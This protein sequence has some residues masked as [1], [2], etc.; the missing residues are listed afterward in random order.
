MKE[1]ILWLPDIMPRH[2]TEYGSKAANLGLIARKSITPQ[3]FCIGTPAYFKTMDYAGVLEQV[4]AL[5]ESVQ[6]KDIEALTA[7]SEEI[8]QIINEINIPKEVEDCIKEHYLKLTG[9]RDGVRVAVRSSATAEDLPNASFAGQLETYLNNESFEEV[10]ESII[11]CWASLWA[12]RAIHYRFQKG[13]GQKNT[14]MA[15][16]VQEMVDSKISGVMFTA[17][18]LTNSRKEIYIEAI[19]GLGEAL[20]QGEKS[21]DRYIVAK[22][23]MFIVSKQ[24]VDGEA[25]LVDFNIKWLANEGLKLQYLCYDQP[26]DIEWAFDKGQIYLLQSRPITTLGDEDPEPLNTDKMTPTQQDIWTNINERFP[27]P[28]LP[29]DS[30]IAKMFYLS[31]FS[32]YDQLGYSVPV[33]DWSRVEEGDFPEFFVPPAI[34]LGFG[35]IF[36]VFKFLDEDIAES[37]QYNEN[38]FNKYLNFL[39]DDTIKE[40]PMEIIVEYIEDALKDFQ[41]ANTFRYFLY[42]QYGTWYKVLAALLTLLY[43]EEGKNIQQDLIA[44]HPQATI[45]LNNQLVNLALTAKVN[46]SVQNTILELQPEKIKNALNSFTAGQEFLKEFDDF[47]FKYGDREV[48]QGLGGIAAATWRDNPE[49]VWGMLK[50]ILLT[51]E[52]NLHSQEDILRRRKVAEEKLME[53]TSK[54]IAKVIPVKGLINKLLDYARKYTAFREDSHFYLTQSMPLFRA[55]FLEI[56]KQMVRRGVL[57]DKNDVL[58][59]TYW[60]LKE[61][62]HDIYSLKKVSKLAISQDLK[63][64]KQRLERR[65]KKWMAR[66]LAIDVSDEDVL[67]GVGASSG[68]ISGVCKVIIDPKDLYRLQPGDIL[69]AQSTNPSWTPVFSF[70]GGLVVEYGSA[71][72]HAAIVAREYGI[73]AVMGVKGITKLLKDNDIVTIDGQLGYVQ[74]TGK[75][76]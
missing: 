36:K 9:D 30:V 48:S 54:G 59:F 33:V 45:E 49:V 52:K 63:D 14:G 24:T 74:I 69:V 38:A 20:V 66:N 43:G 22:E 6:H 10:K 35:R 17:N 61:L 68:K 57:E 16:I 23:G 37:W 5:A 72:S 65:R 8:A 60:E 73:P 70:I 42:I 39:R 29:I 46:D 50:G 55:M 15:V 32:A 31:L 27:E 62:V 18:P 4:V 76:S 25:Y 56:G 64:R 40:F 58:Y 47:I 75:K 1:F 41:R 12:P 71:I 67:R 53:L 28:I 3:G 11:K 7:V 34:T 19:K 26:Q 51:E 2:Q 44:G 13:I 21:G